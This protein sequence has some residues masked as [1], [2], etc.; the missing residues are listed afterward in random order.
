VGNEKK[1]R[2]DLFANKSKGKS[3]EKKAKEN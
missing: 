1:M 2:L 3:F